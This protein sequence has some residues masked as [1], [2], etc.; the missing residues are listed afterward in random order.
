[1]PGNP[2]QLGNTHPPRPPSWTPKSIEKSTEN[3]VQQR[4]ANTQAQRPQN[5]YSGALGP[6][7]GS[8]M[9]PKMEPKVIQK[10]SLHENM[11]N[12]FFVCIYYTSGMSLTSKNRSFFD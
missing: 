10:G 8:K 4:N 2:A 3:K 1:M 11:K 7:N 5:E 12:S 9:S 6:Q